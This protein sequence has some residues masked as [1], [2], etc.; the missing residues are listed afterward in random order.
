MKKLIILTSTGG[1]GHISATQALKEYL[2]TEYQI[3]SVLAFQDPL[4][5][6]DLFSRATSNRISSENLY[7]ILLQHKWSR[8]IN[9]L[10]VVG[11][12][13]FRLMHH[14]VTQ[15][16]INYFEKERPDLIISV[17]PLINGALL[18]AAE[19]LNIPLVIVPTDLDSSTFV[20]GIMRPS[21]KK[22][23]Y[24][25]P[26]NNHMIKKTIEHAGLTNSQ[27]SISGF[28]IRVDFF[29]QKDRVALLQKH[30]IPNN[31]SVIL[32]M[33]GGLG[34]TELIRIIQNLNTI[35]IP[36]H[37]LVC[38]GK[39][40]SLQ[41]TI[42][43]IVLPRHIS[44]TIIGFTDRVSDLMAISDLFITKS[45]SVSVC[46]ALYMNLPMFLD[47]G[48][49]PLTW[50]RLN[51]HYI[52]TQHAGDSITNYKKMPELVTRLLGNKKR[53][54]SIKQEMVH[55][56]KPDPRSQ[57]KIILN[58]LLLSSVS[59]V[60]TYQSVAYPDACYRDKKEQ[61]PVQ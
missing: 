32:V 31:A 36:V 53:I 14:H 60:R 39:S 47:G 37:L 17:I 27:I 21:F 34:C 56:K 9:A 29:E 19:H 25:L 43:L 26:F 49:C 54:L 5:E 4:A 22:F 7:N 20:Q 10:C 1:R 41:E 6:M 57:F 42:S 46:E 59:S 38:I 45:G 11:G 24:C 16:F 51:H 52:K 3:K 50:E 15:L 13:Y 58:E 55:N 2:K 44:I 40:K 12:W 33:L 35:A 8:T 61:S 28:P 18:D 48:T 23:R 30:H